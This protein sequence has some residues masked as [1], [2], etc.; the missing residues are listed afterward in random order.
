MYHI[1]IFFFHVFSDFS[2]Q[3][4]F[5]EFAPLDH[6]PRISKHNKSKKNEDLPVGMTFEASSIFQFLLGLTSDTF[7]VE[8]GRQEDAEEFLTFFLNAL[9]DEMLA[10]LKLLLEDEED[11]LEG[12]IF[13]PIFFLHFS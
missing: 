8:E 5:A 9:N 11:E 7:K 2:F 12:K 3:E 1:R 13:P 4:F 10:L 6:F